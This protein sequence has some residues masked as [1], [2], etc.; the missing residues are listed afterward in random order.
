MSTGKLAMFL[1]GVSC[2]TLMLRLAGDIHEQL[3]T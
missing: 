1:A 3:T 2:V